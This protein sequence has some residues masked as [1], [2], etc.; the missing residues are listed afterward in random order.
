MQVIANET[1]SVPGSNQTYQL[2][3]QDPHG[4][5]GGPMLQLLSG[6]YPTG[7][8]QIALTPGLAS[9]LNLSVGDTW[10]QG[11]KTVVGMVQNPQSLLDEFALVPPGQVAHPTQVN[12]LFD[13]SPSAAKDLPTYVTT[14]GVEQQQHHQPVDHRP[15]VGDGRACS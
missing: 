6:H 3:S 14:P 2:R 15:G 4:P 13:A 1:F 10:P 8:D 9:E 5:Y 11:G 12:V 7:S